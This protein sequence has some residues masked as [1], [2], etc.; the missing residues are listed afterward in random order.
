[1]QHTAIEDKPEIAR[2][3][4]AVLQSV[5]CG[6]DGWY[7]WELDRPYDLILIDG[8]QGKGRRCGVLRVIERLMH[9]EP[10]IVVDDVQRA[11]ERELAMKVILLMERGSK[12]LKAIPRRDLIVSQ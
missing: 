8:T 11:A 4:G 3:A 12:K 7:D 1:M 10:V 5:G 9:K 2:D 6:D